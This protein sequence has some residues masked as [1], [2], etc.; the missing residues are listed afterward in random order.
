MIQ[1]I[2]SLTAAV[3]AGAWLCLAHAAPLP[4][5][6]QQPTVVVKHRY[7]LVIGNARYGV[8]ANALANPA[9]DAQLVSAALRKQDFDVTTLTDLDTAQMRSAVDAFAARAANAEIALVYYAGH[10]VAVDGTNYLFGVDLGVP[11][12]RV[13]LG[14]AQQNAMSMRLIQVALSR[15]HI[16]A[17]LI[18]LDACRTPPVRG[19][20]PAVLT[21]AYAGGGELIA[22]STQPGASANDGFGSNGPQDSPYSYYFAKRLDTQARNEPITEFFQKVTGDVQAATDSSQIPAFTSSLKGSVTLESLTGDTVAAPQMAGADG[23]AGRGAKPALSDELI[24]A[25]LSDWEYEIERNVAYLDVPGLQSLQARA[26]VGDA[27]AMTALGLA[28]EQGV[29]SVVKQNPQAAAQWYRKAAAKNFPIAKTYLGELTAQGLGV[30]KNYA[31]AEQL[32]SEA[33]QAGHRRAAIDLVD[34]RAR[35]GEGMDQKELL[36]AMQG[37]FNDAVQQATRK[38]FDTA[39]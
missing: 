37:V 12:S 4:A 27:I 23:Q 9:R 17:R 32:L 11:V 28:N 34:V 18:V 25:R 5:T 10:A 26:R 29:Q 14:V 7:A 6:A 16:A 38:P 21:K 3:A 8:A 1:F 33:A 39:K 22:Y 13:T 19:A 31:L 30:P 20:A 36:N 2:R 35:R 15:A 24:K